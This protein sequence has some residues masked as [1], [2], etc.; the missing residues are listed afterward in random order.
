MVLAAEN[1]AVAVRAGDATDQVR[2]IRH[3]VSL[4]VQ[5]GFEHAARSRL[6]LLSEG[7]GLPCKACITPSV[8]IR[9][10]PLEG[11]SL[12]RCTGKCPYDPGGG[13]AQGIVPAIKG[14]V[15]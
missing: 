5:R 9:S 14:M 12:L 7:E 6:R 10:I 15:I 11:H 8:A 3:G 13:E 2:A 1:R 4:E